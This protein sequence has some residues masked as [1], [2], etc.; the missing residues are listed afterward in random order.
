MAMVKGGPDDKRQKAIVCPASDGCL[1]SRDAQSFRS[2]RQVSHSCA[3]PGDVW[4][5][6]PARQ[7]GGRTS[8]SL[9][10]L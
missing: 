10:Q 7:R 3:P 1:K 6:K 2:L 9:I 5:V 4:A 8:F